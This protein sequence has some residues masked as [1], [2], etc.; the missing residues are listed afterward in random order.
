MGKKLNLAVL[1]A[2]NANEF[3]AN[4][5]IHVKSKGNIVLLMGEVEREDLIF[6][7]VATTEAVH[8]LLEVYSK[9][10]VASG[11]SAPETTSPPTP[12]A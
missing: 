10:T 1:K 12:I 7:A 9:L 8:P 3:L 11:Q 6:E 5:P 4:Q 2:L